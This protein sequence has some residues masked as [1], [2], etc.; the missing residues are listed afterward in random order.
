MPS[1]SDERSERAENRRSSGAARA[2]SYLLAVVAVFVAAASRWLIDPTLGTHLP[3]PTFFLAVIVAAWVGGLGPALLATVLGLLV[4]WYGFVPPRFS[5][6]KATFADVLGLVMFTAVSCAIA[7][8]STSSRR[9]ISRLEDSTDRHGV[10]DAA[11]AR[12]ASSGSIRQLELATIAG[13][14]LLIFVLAAG[15]SLGH[16]AIGRSLRDRAHVS[17][18]HAVI[19]ELDV[20]LSHV[21]DAETGQRGYLLTER[22]EYLQPYEAALGAI[23]TDIASLRTLLADRA[24]A[25]TVLDALESKVS[26]KLDELRSTVELVHADERAAAL[27]LV[28]TDA[29]QELMDGIRADVA[30]LQAAERELLALHEQSLAAS[31]RNALVAIV[32]PSALGVMLVLVG[33]S[34]F[35]RN[36]LQRQRSALVLAEQEER[37]RT[38]LSSIGDAVIATD[39]EGAVTYLNPVAEHMTGWTISE[40]SG[41]PLTTVFHIVNESTRQTVE[42]PALRALH[43]GVIVGLANHTI[44]I[45]K[46]GTERP[47]D[48]SAAPIRRVDGAIVGCVLVFRDITVR[49]QAE[50]EQETLRESLAASAER[51]AENEARYRA[52]GESI[53]FGVWMC[54]VT[55]RNTYASDSF[56]RLVGITREQCADFGW[57]DVLHPDDAQQTIAAWQECVRTGTVWDRE[58]RFKGVDGQWHYVLARGVPVKDR[59]GKVTGWAGINLDIDRLKHAE[60][61]LRDADRRKDDFLATLAHE[62]R[63]PLAPVRNAVQIL[64]MKGPPVPELEWAREVIDR[65]MQ[66]MARIIDDLM[67]VSRISRNK[68][69]LR[70]DRITLAK[71]LQGAIET[72]RPLIEQLSHQLIVSMPEQS[73]VLHADLTRL[74]QVFVNLLNNAAKYTPTGGTIRLTAQRS[75]ADV[76]VVIRDTGV[77]IPA[78][79]LGT[80]FDMFSQIA[81]ASTHSHGGLGIGLSL[82]KRLVEMHGGSIEVRSDGLGHGSEFLVRLPVHAESAAHRQDHETAEQAAPVSRFRIL[83]VDDNRDAAL[84]TAMMLQLMGNTVRTAHDGEDAVSAAGEFRPHI[85]LMDIGMPRMDGYEACRRIRAQPWGHKMLVI[86]ISGWGQED[87]RRRSEQAGIDRHLVK[88]VN[89]VVLTK[90]LAELS[91]DLALDESGVG[92][93]EPGTR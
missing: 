33:L 4:T 75:G 32:L 51:L 55:G 93:T 13:S 46:D 34:L 26:V 8:L 30:A 72:S 67:D 88:P 5:F 10:G 66:A 48:D 28:M 27:M 65:Q 64:Q 6:E 90:V 9:A 23:A 85:V 80:V 69:E 73:V 61:A 86:A 39:A 52:I 79:K 84:S 16:R 25:S 43:Q 83:V 29:G 81:N 78:D 15:G 77:G 38:T 18:S 92:D 58:H 17:H 49:R 56:L 60:A 70:K 1:P 24:S 42:N 91:A 37:W 68:L 62:L 35:R 63:N 20:L 76:L 74:A 3:Y 44:L 71:V 2:G 53:D 11:G 21:K 87:D 40:A 41:V 82:V 89:P 22:D 57:G 54:D 50:I 47:I 36:L 14:A 7:V 59:D 31:D 19:H 45:A 12:R